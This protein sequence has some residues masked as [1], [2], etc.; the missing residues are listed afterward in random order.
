MKEDPPAAEP[1]RA[2]QDR[3][4]APRLWLASGNAVTIGL[5]HGSL[6]PRHAPAT[7]N[8]TRFSPR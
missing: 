2:F 4:L 1:V 3:K 5:A 7:P 6:L 8:D